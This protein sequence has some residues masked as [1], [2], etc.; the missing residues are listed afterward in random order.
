[1]ISDLGNCKRHIANF[2]KL[3][4]CK[5]RMWQTSKIISISE[6]SGLEWYLRNLDLKQFDK[7]E[8]IAETEYSCLWILF[9]ILIF[10]T[11]TSCLMNDATYFNLVGSL[12][13]KL[14]F[15]RQ[16]SCK[17]KLTEMSFKKLIVFCRLFSNTFCSKG[18]AIVLS[19]QSAKMP[20]IVM[21]ILRG[22]LP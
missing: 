6:G 13:Q 9:K 3:A 7:T 18:C 4:I 2:R 19:P 11:T 10:M 20:R 17:L 21:Q 14:N 22:S 12:N 16:F 1:M 8:I 5:D 15:F